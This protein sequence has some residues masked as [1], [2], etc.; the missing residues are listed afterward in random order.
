VPEGVRG[1][2]APVLVCVDGE[3]RIR[4]YDVELEVEGATVDV[5]STITDHGEAPSL[6]PL[7][8]DERP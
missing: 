7:G 2:R 4:R 1:L 8:P 3:G 5:R 6:E